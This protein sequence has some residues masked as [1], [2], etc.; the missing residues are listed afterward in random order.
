MELWNDLTTSIIKVRLFGSL[1][2]WETLPVNVL[3][4]NQSQHRRSVRKLLKEQVNK[5]KHA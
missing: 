1:Y 2:N 3:D 5:D 4:L